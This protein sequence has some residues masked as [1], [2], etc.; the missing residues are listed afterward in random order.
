MQFNSFS[1]FQETYRLQL[2]DQQKKAVRA[3]DGPVLLLAVPG[4][5]KTTVLVS[6]LGYMIYA[7]GIDPASI[8]TVTYTVAAAEDMKKRYVSCF[9]DRDVDRMK[10]QTINAFCYGV[11]AYHC[12][13]N[14]KPMP[15]V[16]SDAQQT[17]ILTGIYRELLD[18]FPTPADI[19]DL[20]TKL[21]YVKNMMLKDREI[22]KL[23][24]ADDPLFDIYTRYNAALRKSRMIDFDDQMV[25]ALS[26]LRKDP[27]LLG[28]I[29]GR[30]RYYCVDEAQDT[31]KIQHE[32]LKLLAGEAHN[33]FMVG[34]EDQSIYGFRAAYPQA[35]LDFE[36]DH[37]GAKV[38]YLEQN[39]RSD[40]N[41]VTLADQLIRHN[42]A[43]RDKNMQAARDARQEVTFLPVPDAD[44]QYAALLKAAKD[45]KTQTAVLY[46]ENESA[47]PLADLLDRQGIPFN[48]KQGDLVFFSNRVVKD[49]T[50]ILAFS[51]NPMDA[52]CFQRIYSKCG[53]YIK[54]EQVQVACA[55]A[56]RE[57]A[58][59]PDIL[60]AS[61]YLN[62]KQKRSLRTFC[63]D[64]VLLPKDT[65]AHAVGRIL[66]LMGYA[67]Y[68]ERG[69]LDARK[70]EILQTLAQRERTVPGF[71]RRLETL[72]ALIE[73]KT[74]DPACR[75]TLST[76]HSAKGLEYD[77][78]YLID[79]FD[80]VLPE[81]AIRVTRHTPP[82]DVER[83]EEDRRIF[84][85][86][87]TRAKKKLNIFQLQNAPLHVHRRAAKAR[88]AE[89]NGRGSRRIDAD[90][91]G[92]GPGSGGDRLPPQL[93]P[94]RHH[95][96]DL[97]REIHNDP[98][99]F[100]ADQNLRRGRTPQKQ[101]AVPVYVSLS[102][103]L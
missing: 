64:L 15:A 11:L 53:L 89:K 19:K 103:G 30:Y 86:G 52:E 83:L 51:L 54:K 13:R 92:L 61:E 48:I 93:R 76:I 24:S 2:N 94:R 90:L 87:I 20:K 6:R 57:R 60:L 71:L 1:E 7:R 10:F 31:S 16:V 22:R 66:H 102:G 50:D 23:S 21:G 49:I 17:A 47:I 67:E 25:Y 5:G 88:P 101:A 45:C 55:A 77:T 42:R 44:A 46:R 35:L 37:P 82:E 75:L 91:A 68:M 12:K 43:R 72:R 4:S 69:K 80:G 26:L 98:V 9:G 81:N 28:L 65:A 62:E 8:L 56:L 78:V 3:V 96:V 73:Q 38:L 100:R 29:R 58:F 85:V 27:A 74:Y 84:Y 18:D 32:I 14:G 41:I 95:G 39:F 97:Q 59:A 34:D 99:P 36:K 79:V 63:R 70:A 40:R 33:L